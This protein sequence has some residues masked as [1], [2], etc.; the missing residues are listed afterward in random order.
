MC[1][2]ET[3]HFD[4][5]KSTLTSSGIRTIL[6]NRPN[7]NNALTIQM[8]ED[9]TKILNDAAK[10]GD[11]TKIIYITGAGEKYFSSGND[12]LNYF[13]KGDYDPV[14]LL[15]NA[16][17]TV[18][19]FFKAF[20]D[21]PK[22]GSNNGLLYISRYTHQYYILQCMCI[23]LPSNQIY[24][25]LLVVVGVNGHAIGVAVTILGLVDIVYASE[26]ASFVTP[27][28]KLALVAEGCSTLT[29]PR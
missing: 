7:R 14:A 5:I 12:L 3:L 22:I 24:F 25:Q 18:E 29:F 20:I 8:F 27:F 2:T 13:P 17:N 28:T 26:E 9:I 4:G 1:I 21:F 23:D 11:K 19:E 10:D 6:L 16:T 15:E